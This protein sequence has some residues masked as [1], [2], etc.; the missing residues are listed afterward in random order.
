MLTCRALIGNFDVIR[1]VISQEDPHQIL[2]IIV[3]YDPIRRNSEMAT[4][5]SG[6]YNIFVSFKYVS[7]VIRVLTRECWFSLNLRFQFR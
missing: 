5:K 7:D 1:R 6:D 2:Y 3:E 4:D